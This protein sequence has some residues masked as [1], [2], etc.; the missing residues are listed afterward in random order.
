[1][2]NL[3]EIYKDM[4]A[5]ILCAGQGTRL[6]PLTINRP[7]PML[8]ILNKPVLVHNLEWLS[9][10]GINEFII[11]LHHKPDYIKE[12]FKDKRIQISV[13]MSPQKRSDSRL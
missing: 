5:F 7:K 2:L 1:M 10:Q 13:F 8:P 4:K 9:N 11:N 6:T 3:E 12:Y